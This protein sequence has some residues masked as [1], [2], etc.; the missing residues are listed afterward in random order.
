MSSRL[1][2]GAED[3]LRYLTCRGY[4]RLT[5]G[6]NSPLRY[7]KDLGRINR[8]VGLLIECD[9]TY[10][11]VIDGLGN[12][13]LLGWCMVTRCPLTSSLYTDWSSFLIPGLSVPVAETPMLDYKAEI[14]LE[15]ATATAECHYMLSSDTAK[16]HNKA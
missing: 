7:L 12:M 4:E 6:Y 3:V 5:Q 8:I 11:V 16:G 10:S 14:C 1:I 2:R 9:I 13:L 15:C